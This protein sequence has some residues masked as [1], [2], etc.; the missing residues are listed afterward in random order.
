[1]A[2]DGVD[3]DDEFCGD[4]GVTAPGYQEGEYALFLRGEWF[5]QWTIRVAGLERERMDKGVED[6][7]SIDAQRLLRE[8][9][10]VLAQEFSQ[11]FAFVEEEAQES[12]AARLGENRGK[13]LLALSSLLKRVMGKRVEELDLQRSYGILVFLRVGEQLL[14]QRQYALSLVASQVQARGEQAD[15]LLLSRGEF[16]RETGERVQGVC[17]SLE[18]AIA[19]LRPRLPE[20]DIG[21]KLA[22]VGRGLQAYDERGK[23]C[24]CLG[25]LSAGSQEQKPQ[26]F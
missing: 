23:R 22:R 15:G 13:L 24:L 20:Q 9:W 1:M 14:K 12:L 8:G 21:D 2:F 4:S 3:G 19:D 17:R 25:H 18:S 16:L 26:E 10:Q 5:E 6:V 11:S 7:L